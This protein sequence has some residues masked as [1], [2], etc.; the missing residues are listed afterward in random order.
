LLLGQNPLSEEQ[1][2]AE[3]AERQGLEEQVPGPEPELVV[4]LQV[5]QEQP[6]L[7]LQ[8]EQLEQAVPVH[9]FQQ[10]ERCEA[11][12]QTPCGKQLVLR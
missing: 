12:E 7:L 5:R 6:E 3:P 11:G 2:G 9:H 1:R 8:L 10:H 4:E